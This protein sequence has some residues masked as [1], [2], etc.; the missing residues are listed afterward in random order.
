MATIVRLTKT[1]H[2]VL[3]LVLNF[4]SNKEIASELGTSVRTAK[5]H[6][7]NILH[8]YGVSYRAD[9]FRQLCDRASHSRPTEEEPTVTNA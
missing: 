4:R 8:K 5:F 9:L 1:E 7:S 3:P 6:V 2:I